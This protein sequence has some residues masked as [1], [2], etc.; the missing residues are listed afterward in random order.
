MQCL[1]ATILFLMFA[2]LVTTFCIMF[3]RSEYKMI[4][5]NF[6]QDKLFAKEFGHAQDDCGG[7]WL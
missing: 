3:Y 4:L 2:V 5:E 6:E 1:V 7:M